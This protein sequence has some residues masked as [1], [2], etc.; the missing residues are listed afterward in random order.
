MLSLGH[1]TVSITLDAYSRAFLARAVSPTCILPVTDGY[2]QEVEHLAEER[3]MKRIEVIIPPG[4]VKAVA[5]A[6]AVE[7]VT[8]M[9]ISE[10]RGWGVRQRAAGPQTGPVEVELSPKL[11]VEIV[12]RATDV[13]AVMD[14]VTEALENSGLGPAKMFSSAVESAVHT[15]SG[16]R[17]HQALAWRF[18]AGN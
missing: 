7:G 3:E 14:R 13:S 11:K 6:L 4:D 5:Q 1:A 10:V 16:A 17:D 12:V 15:R 8:G 9:T 2:L 18:V